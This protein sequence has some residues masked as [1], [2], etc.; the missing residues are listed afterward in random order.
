MKTY[1]KIQTL[2]NITIN[3]EFGTVSGYNELG[4]K[5]VMTK[6]QFEELYTEEK[7]V[8]EMGRDFD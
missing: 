5:V 4:S 7:P 8:F 2:T 3:E 1:Y 6:K